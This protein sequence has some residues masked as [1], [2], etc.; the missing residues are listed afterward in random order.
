VL[1]EV[2]F[3]LSGRPPSPSIELMGSIWFWILTNL[4]NWLLPSCFT[5]S[6]SVAEHGLASSSESGTPGVQSTQ[7]SL[8]L[9]PPTL[10]ATTELLWFWIPWIGRTHSFSQLAKK[11]QLEIGPTGQ[12]KTKALDGRRLC[13]SS[14]AISYH[15]FWENRGHSVLIRVRDSVRHCWSEDRL[16][17]DN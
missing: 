2:K 10:L 5:Y 8:P 3:R 17:D 12:N 9:Q 4:Q 7:R 14:C 16:S 11:V 15:L 1:C 6:C 13:V